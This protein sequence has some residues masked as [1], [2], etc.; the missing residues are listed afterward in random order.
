M[1]TRLAV[2]RYEPL[3][4][5]P[6]LLENRFFVGVEHPLAKSVV[7]SHSFVGEAWGGNV[8]SLGTCA[9]PSRLS[10]MSTVSGEKLAEVRHVGKLL[11]PTQSKPWQFGGVFGAF[12]EPSQARR[13]FV[14]YLHAERPGRRTP[15]VHY[16]SWYDFYSYQDEGFN[17]GFN[18][19]EPD[20]ALIAS[21]RK[22][23]LSEE[24]CL[25]VR[26]GFMF[27]ITRTVDLP[28]SE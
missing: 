25:K 27:T 11:P 10:V 23:Q 9:I 22:D 4:G 12:S 18:D 15:M 3:D 8:D 13:A 19:P 24:N 7:T 14:S 21:L 26:E 16:N 5:L 6:F 2:D 28:R 20:P 17:G 1:E